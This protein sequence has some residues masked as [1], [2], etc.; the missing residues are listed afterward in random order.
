MSKK[1]GLILS[2]FVVAVVP[3]FAFANTFAHV[4]L[5]NPL[6]CGTFQLCVCQIAGA[7]FTIA[8]PIAIVMIIYGAFQM[9]IA[10]GEPEKFATARKTITY[11][12]AGLAVIMV[13]RGIIV[14]VYNVLGGKG[15]LPGC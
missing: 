8:V 3:I 5:K 6:G 1:T 2:L 4:T 9:M 15:T 10:T 12:I 14:V 11:A 7:L 13:S